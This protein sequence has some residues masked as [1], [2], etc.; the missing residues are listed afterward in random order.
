MESKELDNNGVLYRRLEL[1]RDGYRQSLD[2]LKSSRGYV[3]ED[4]VELAPSTE[5]L[6][7]ICEK[8]VVEHHHAEDE[9]RFVL[10]GE[11]VFDIRSRE[12]AW[13]R[14]LVE[15]GDLIV[16]PGGRHHRFMLT[17]RRHIRCV[18]LFRDQSGWVPHYR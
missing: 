18:R 9:V 10:E 13:M 3:Q 14:V 12:D 7:Q 11:G 5:N 16:V 6:D 15:P 8:F 4:S 2:E 17:Q 1:E